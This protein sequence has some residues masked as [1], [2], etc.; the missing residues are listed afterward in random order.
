[1]TEY[2]AVVTWYPGGVTFEGE[3]CWGV[4]FPEDDCIVSPG[5]CDQRRKHSKAERK[6]KRKRK[7]ARE[8][9][10]VRR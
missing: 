7:A 10:R 1:M 8:A 4:W 5:W 2:F 6:R 9:R 3:R